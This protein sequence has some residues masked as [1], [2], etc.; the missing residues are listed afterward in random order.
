MNASLFTLASALT[1]LTSL[2]L[3]SPLFFTSTVEPSG[4]TSTSVPSGICKILLFEL[5]CALSFSFNKAL[6]FLNP[7]TSL[8]LW[9]A[10]SDISWEKPSPDKSICPV[11]V[12]SPNKLREESTPI[13]AIAATSLGAFLAVSA[14]LA[15][16]PTLPEP[17]PISNSAALTRASC[18][19][20]LF[21]SS[22]GFSFVFSLYASTAIP[23]KDEIKPPPSA[24]GGKNAI[25]PTITTIPAICTVFLA[26]CTI[27]SWS[28]AKDDA[29]ADASFVP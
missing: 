26:V 28:C 23:P 13:S 17:A 8:P 24:A 20:S 2:A 18:P 29:N 22:F 4:F 5:A 27:P 25:P 11:S 21:F 9:P 16:L 1:G 19:S 10:T 15:I 7:S 3:P 14:V 12:K 6:P